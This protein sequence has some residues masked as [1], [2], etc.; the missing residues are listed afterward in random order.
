M[1]KKVYI[2]GSISNNPGYKKQF[3]DAERF[4]REHGDIPL[5]PA[6]LP[7][8]MS[9]RDYMQICISMIGISH[10]AVFLPGWE[11]SE[12]AKVE[13][14]FCEKCGIQCFEWGEF[15]DIEN[16]IQETL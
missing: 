16:I 9:Q 12:G 11:V 14:M 2:A 13:R 5:N 1:K 4:I 15:E 7:A 8:G 3:G 6:V 10:F